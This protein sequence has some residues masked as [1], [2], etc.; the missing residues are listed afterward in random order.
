MA[1]PVSDMQKQLLET[2]RVNV[3]WMNAL[4]SI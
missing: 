2:V 1:G 3:D 4:V